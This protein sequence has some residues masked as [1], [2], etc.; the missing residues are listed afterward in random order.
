[1]ETSGGSTST[2]MITVPIIHPWHICTPVLFRYLPLQYVDEFFKD[3][4]LRLSSFAL[5]KKHQD[6]QR[7]DKNEGTV[8]F[9]HRSQ[10]GSG[11][12]IE[13]WGHYGLNAYVLSATMLHNEDLLKSFGCNSY[14]RI[15]NPTEFGICIAKHVP[16]L[17]AGLEGPCL[18]QGMKIIERDLG[19]IDITKFKDP[20]DPSKL[21]K[22]RLDRFIIDQMK[23][24]P[25]FLK[26]KSFSHQA[27]YR[28]LWITSSPIDG[29]IDIK[30][31][32]AI[33]LCSRSSPLTE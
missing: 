32:E 11:Q 4:S 7:L 21:A 19:F 18:Y 28:L 24:Y 23:H 17:E 25:F 16:G 14:I 9:V 15:N 26:E 10:Q 2:P 12:T 3:G 27:E 31:P 30:V 6:E 8:F 33:P 5:F 20:A 13:A 29:F 22:P 1:M